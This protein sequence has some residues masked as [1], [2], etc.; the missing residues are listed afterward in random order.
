LQFW[1]LS[2]ISVDSYRLDYD[3]TEVKALG[4]EAVAEQDISL[5]P[6]ARQGLLSD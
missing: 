5:T 4:P 1:F 2:W 6:F 3:R